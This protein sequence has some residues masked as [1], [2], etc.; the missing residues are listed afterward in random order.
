MADC[1]LQPLSQP[2]WPINVFLNLQDCIIILCILFTTY[3]HRSRW[4]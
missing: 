4:G 1:L 3:L 2:A